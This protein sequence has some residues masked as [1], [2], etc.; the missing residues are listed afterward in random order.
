MNSATPRTILLVAAVAALTACSGKPEPEA[1][2]ET[3]PETSANEPAAA[4][5]NRIDIPAAVRQNLGITFVKVEPRRVE[6]TLRTPGR[7]EFLPTA[8]R[9]YRTSLAGRVEIL[10]DQFDT[11]QPGTPLYQID[12]PAWR[13][14]QRDLTD[15]E[16]A[17]E[18][19]T[20]RR[21]SYDP[22]RKAHHNHEQQ[23]TRVIEIHNQRIAQLEALAIAGG[24]RLAELTEARGT[25]AAAQADLA[26]VLEKE[27]ELEADEAETISG[28]AAARSSREL[29]LDTAATLTGL[30]TETLTETVE[31]P[32]GQHPR[33]RTLTSIQV[34]ARE[35]GIVESLGLTDGAWADEKTPVVTTLQPDRI[36]FH[37][38]ALQ[39][40]LGRLRDGLPARIVTPQITRIAGAID[41]SQTMT[42]TLS[43][44][45]SGDPDDRTIDIF[46]VPDTLAPWARAGITSQLEIITDETAAPVLAVPNAAI[47]TDGLERVIFRR[48]PADPNRAIRLQADLGLSD[49][50]WTAVNSGLR[51]GDEVVLD[52]AFQLMLASANAGQDAGGHFHADGTF[53]SGEDE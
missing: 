34:T 3:T 38:S 21:D 20:F 37:A 47:Q 23:L 26:E 27:A 33:W 16:L 36:R 52:G 9:E 18:R 6:A 5:S 12:S 13:S 42:G 53:H 31:S 44:G 48:D 50:R 39:S 43:I 49:G 22:L 15:A 1:T 45:L 2:P 41:M 29:L 51:T 35:P 19:L 4:P 8:R 25:A 14:L 28:L 46:V 32:R 30:S 11:V 7:F 17:I 40:D 24:G 10:V